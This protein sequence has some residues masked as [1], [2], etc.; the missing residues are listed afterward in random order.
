MNPKLVAVTVKLKDVGLRR[1]VPTDDA[2]RG[3]IQDPL[4]DGEVRTRLRI[5]SD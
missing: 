1:D 5:G 4:V 2:F 3:S